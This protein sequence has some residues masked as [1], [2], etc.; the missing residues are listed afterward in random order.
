MAEID[1]LGRYLT[2][3]ILYVEAGLVGQI[4]LSSVIL[5][6]RQSDGGRTTALVR[7]RRMS[8]SR[9]CEYARALFVVFT[10]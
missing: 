2:R 8:W 10:A 9:D 3:D 4:K 6:N 7:S 5:A 1:A